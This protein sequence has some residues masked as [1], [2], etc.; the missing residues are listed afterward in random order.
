VNSNVPLLFLRTTEKIETEINQKG[1]VSTTLESLQRVRTS[2]EVADQ[3][4]ITIGSNVKIELPDKSI[5]SGTIREIGDIAVWPQG[6]QTGNPFLEVSVSINGDI[7]F[8]Q[9]TGA[10]VTVSI[11][12]MLVKEVLA[13]PI[14]SLVALLGGGY[15]LEIFEGDSIRLVA[16]ETG[17]Y[18]DGWVEV[19]GDDLAEGTEVVVAGR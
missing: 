10:V 15:G 13:V 19:L 3:E 12:Q 11:T 14:P 7:V 8:H 5:V 4:L 17:V 18:D 2:I 16:V 1:E 6:D 9:W